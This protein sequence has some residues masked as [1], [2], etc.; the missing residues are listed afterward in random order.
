MTPAGRIL[1]PFWLGQGPRWEAQCCQTHTE[2]P[3]LSHGHMGRAGRCR[4]PRNPHSLCRAVGSASLTLVPSCF[5]TLFHQALQPIRGPQCSDPDSP[6]QASLRSWPLSSGRAVTRDQVQPESSILHASAHLI[7]PVLSLGLSLLVC[8]MG[9]STTPSSLS[10][11]V[12]APPR[13][14][15]RPS[16]L[17]QKQDFGEAGGTP[18][19]PAAE[20]LA[21]C[22]RLALTMRFPHTIPRNTALP[23]LPAR[24]TGGHSTLPLP[25]GLSSSR[26]RGLDE[27]R[28]SNSQGSPRQCLP[29][30]QAHQPCPGGERQR[31]FLWDSR[32]A[33]PGA[34]PHSQSDLCLLCGWRGGEYFLLPALGHLHTA[35]WSGELSPVTLLL[36]SKLSQ[37]PMSSSEKEARLSRPPTALVPSP[38]HACRRAFAHTI[39]STQNTLPHVS[40][41]CVHVVFRVGST[42]PS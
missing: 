15:P 33:G 32:P 26:V 30:V 17:P 25:R 13:D 6:I 42:V 22:S 37:A 8:R 28:R 5:C 31:K 23:A 11:K 1:L 38:A 3:P 29:G 14:W 10:W 9:R 2:P 35:A 20:A 40:L 36:C 21:A 16:S 24:Q 27:S 41:H 34:R 7:W 18:Q 19:R 39:S 4:S 12:P